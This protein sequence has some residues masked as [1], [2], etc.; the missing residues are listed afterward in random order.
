[1]PF[2][3]NGDF[4]T[5]I[6]KSVNKKLFLSSKVKDYMF[7]ECLQ[8]VKFIHSKNIVHRDIKLDNF[9]IDE[10]CVLKLTDFG[11]SIDLHELDEESSIFNNECNQNIRIGTKSYRAPELCDNYNINSNNNNNNSSNSSSNGN[12]VSNITKIKNYYK[13][14][15]WSLAISYI[16]LSSN[17]SKPWEIADKKSCP[18]FKCFR[19]LY[20]NNDLN[21]KI[22]INNTDKQNSWIK[23]LVKVNNTK[24]TEKVLNFV[25]RLSF[26]SK[27][28]VLKMLNVDPNTRA[29]INDV[30]DS[31]WMSN[32]VDFCTREELRESVESILR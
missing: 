1:M 13:L 31:D 20:I 6:A 26:D 16:L 10:N 30:W 25:E 4:F 15:V 28:V 14:D 17:I 3:S 7:K 21:N 29:S 22:R 23:N 8:A 32:R 11:M 27:S 12:T 9:L 18:S 24:E 19:D 5:L 2:Y